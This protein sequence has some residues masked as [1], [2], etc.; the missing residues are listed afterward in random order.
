MEPKQNLYFFILLIN[1]IFSFTDFKLQ[2][3]YLAYIDILITVLP[4]YA[5]AIKFKLH[6]YKTSTS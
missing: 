2:K 6:E 1:L 5:C 3:S 4:W